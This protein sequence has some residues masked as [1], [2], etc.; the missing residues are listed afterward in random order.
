MYEIVLNHYRA[1]PLDLKKMFK[2]VQEHE[3]NME[4]PKKIIKN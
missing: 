3:T 1:V 4:K 2:T